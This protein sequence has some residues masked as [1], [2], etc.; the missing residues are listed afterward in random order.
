MHRSLM[1]A[2]AILIAGP[3][4]HAHKGT[5]PETLRLAESLH[6]QGGVQLA[7]AS[8]GADCASCHNAGTGAII[9][10]SSGPDRYEQEYKARVKAAKEARESETEAEEEPTE[11]PSWIPIPLDTYGGQSEPKPT[12]KR[13][14]RQLPTHGGYVIRPAP[15]SKKS[16]AAPPHRPSTG[17]PSTGYVVRSA[18]PVEAPPPPDEE[19]VDQNGVIQL[20]PPR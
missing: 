13:V 12:V 11:H 20:V 16:V 18:T 17:S 2:F 10:D 7:Y 19:P 14:I 9:K 1:V 4:C 3:V 15:Q 6:A 8:M 5:G